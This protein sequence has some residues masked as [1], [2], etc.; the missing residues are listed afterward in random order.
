[1]TFSSMAQLRARTWAKMEDAIRE[2]KRNGF[3]PKGSDYELREIKAGDVQIVDLTGDDG[4]V[5]QIDPVAETTES[6][7]AAAKIAP[8]TRKANGKDHPADADARER[9]AKAGSFNVHFRISPSKKIN[10]PAPTETEAI[11]IAHELNKEH[12]GKN[13]RRATIYAIDAKGVGFPVTYDHTVPIATATAKGL[14]KAM[15]VSVKQLPERCARGIKKSPQKKAV[16]A[17][18]VKPPAQPEAKPEPQPD[19]DTNDLS[20]LP[21]ARGPFRIVLGH[22]DVELP[23]ERVLHWALECARRLKE[24]VRV[25]TLKGD[26]VRSLDYRGGGKAKRQP[27]PRSEGTRAPRATGKSAEAVKLLL[28][29]N[30]ATK[31]EIVAVTE[32]SF[33]ERYIRRLAA[34]NNAEMKSLGKDHWRLVKA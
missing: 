20:S 9:A 2:L 6:S 1:M 11:A 7:A 33:G 22:E 24:H 30:G 3:K 10:R 21:M 25:V 8:V 12:G 17:A 34:A 28:R 23:S 16:D 14:D 19:D 4:P 27:K 29:K 31:A 13:G 26:V 15:Q 18:K 5:K 32:W